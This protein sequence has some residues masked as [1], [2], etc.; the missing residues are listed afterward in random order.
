M[1]TGGTVPQIP[2]GLAGSLGAPPQTGGLDTSLVQPP[3]EAPPPATPDPLVALQGVI[4]DFP[5]LLVALPDPGDV[6][7]VTKALAILT[8]VQKRLMGQSGTPPQAA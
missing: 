5:L 2:G 1:I 4:E 8:N 6:H 7:D 3:A